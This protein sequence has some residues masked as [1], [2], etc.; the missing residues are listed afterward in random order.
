MA[1]IKHIALTTKE[2]AKTA[3]FYKAAFGL[4]E[5]RRNNGNVFLTD[6]YVHIGVLRGCARYEGAWSALY[7]H[8]SFRLRGRRSRRNRPETGGGSGSSA[9]GERCQRRRAARRGSRQFRA[10]MVGSGRRRCRR[11]AYRL[12]RH[13]LTRKS[14]ALSLFPPNG[15]FGAN[16][17]RRR[18]NLDVARLITLLE[19]I[20][21][22]CARRRSRSQQ[23]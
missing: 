10:E 7:W 23:L 17:V 22:S 12:G 2:P 18:Y 13:P 16:P 5:L 15:A 14:F 8:S 20:I 3:E 21:P 1:R 4:K 6:G 11:L 19:D 9:D